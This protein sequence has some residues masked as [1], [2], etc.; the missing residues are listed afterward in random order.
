[1]KRFRSSK[2]LAAVVAAALVALL[3][4]WLIVMPALA[5]RARL[6]PERSPLVVFVVIDALRRD[7]IGALGYGRATTPNLDR[8][9]DEGFVVSG[10]LAH[11]SQTAPS[12]ASMF[13]STPPHVHGVQYN[14][15][16]HRFGNE[17]R[18]K[19]PL[20]A[21]GNLTLAE[22]LSKEGYFTAGA[23][24]NPWLREKFGYAQGFDRYVAL[25]C[26]KRGR[27]ICDGSRINQEAT[28]IIRS[29]PAHK[30]FLYLHYMD[31]HNPYAHAGRLRRVFR[32][33]P[34]HVVYKNGMAPD[35]SKEDVAYSIDA[36]D[37]GLLYTDRLIG[38]LAAELQ[39]AADARDVLL[40]VTS[41]HGDEFLEHGGLG[42]GST[43][44]PELIDTFA[45]FWRPDAR[46]ERSPVGGACGSVD[47]APTILDLVRIQKPPQ[48][49]GN[50]LLQPLA[51]GA[52]V[53]E[54]AKKKAVIKGGWGLIRDLS[55]GQEEVVA[56]SAGHG[57]EP[58]P[59]LVEDLR[60]R[61]DSLRVRET[62][63]NTE[64]PDSAVV[65][66]L[67]ALGYME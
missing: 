58:D 46:L 37:D 41:D 33:G 4:F 67:K 25:P 47:I 30:T 54:L 16:T 22:V 10:M 19:A 40:V 15:R 59:A 8:L 24:A 20:L 31:V 13:T 14:P 65:Q 42:H 36:Y 51:G 34:G 1:M 21:E 53:S 55:T 35:V 2:V 50:S 38:K 43:L 63:V 5:S 49:E 44:Y 12:V 62:P 45:I 32:K 27:G 26:H 66:Q 3:G 60:L 39:A 7:H 48:M 23:V 52:I 56:Y 11:A 9:I 29:H 57:A 18:S 6:D 64:V 28:K 61:L 17:G